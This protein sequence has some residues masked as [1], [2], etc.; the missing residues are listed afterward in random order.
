MWCRSSL[1]GSSSRVFLSLR[2]T[3]LTTTMTQADL[4]V[5]PPSFA[6]PHSPPAFQQF[7]KEH[8]PLHTSASGQQKPHGG[9]KETTSLHAT[10]IQLLSDSISS[11]PT[12]HSLL[13]EPHPPVH[14][15][16][17]CCTG[18][19]SVRL[20]YEMI[21]NEISRQRL[22]TARRGLRASREM[23]AA[24]TD[25]LHLQ[26]SVQPRD[27]WPGSKIPNRM[28]AKRIQL[29]DSRA[30]G[31]MGKVQSLSLNEGTNGVDALGKFP[32]ISVK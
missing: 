10:G 23:R 3:G 22:A 17:H 18:C 9:R 20:A 11:K 13:A 28:R 29:T 1:I 24:G 15:Y 26:R 6:F 16:L 2:L 19:S 7:L 5:C 27:N 32:V 8:I 31:S 21:G 12:I 25:Q 30:E 4:S 14:G